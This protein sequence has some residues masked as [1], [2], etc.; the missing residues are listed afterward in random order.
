MQHGD[1]QDELLFYRCI[2]YF[3]CVVMFYK[4]CTS[5]NEYLNNGTNTCSTGD[6]SLSSE[7]RDSETS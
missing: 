7:Q 5:R 6:L 1:R 3:I 4:T 2:N